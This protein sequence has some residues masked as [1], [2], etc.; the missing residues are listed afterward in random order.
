MRN[1]NKSVA[2]KE[3]STAAPVKASSVA[4]AQAAASKTDATKVEESASKVAVPEVKKEETV[5]P[6]E[7]VK[8][9]EKKEEKP[10]EKAVAKVEEKPVTEK[11]KPGRKPGRKPA[12]EKAA[13]KKVAKKVE[14]VSVEEVYFEYNHEQVLSNELVERIKMEYKNE[15]H[16]ISSI[17]SL[18]V[19]VNVVDRKAY[20][21]INDKAEGKFVEF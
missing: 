17:K 5:K 3:V 15:G 1:K 9:E 16:R 10:V 2:K 12:S 6:A 11:K 4:T 21:V 14:P 8:K 13:A 19:Y 7:A 18:K 20:Y